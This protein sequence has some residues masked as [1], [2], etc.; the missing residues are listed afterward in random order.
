M[1]SLVSRLAVAE[2][3]ATEANVESTRVK[4]ANVSADRFGVTT[5]RW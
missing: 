2:T 4:L 1:A 5:H 3:V